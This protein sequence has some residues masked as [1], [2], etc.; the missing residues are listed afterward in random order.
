A[1]YRCAHQRL[2]PITKND[3]LHLCSQHWQRET[4]TRATKGSLMQYQETE[5]LNNDFHFTSPH[6]LSFSAQLSSFCYHRYLQT[7]FFV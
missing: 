2:R 7:S 4:R 5:H 3:H 1:L 6:Q